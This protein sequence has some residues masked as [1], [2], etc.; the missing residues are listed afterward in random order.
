[1]KMKMLVLTIAM[2]FALVMGISAVAMAGDAEKGKSV[3]NGAG[4]CK[5]CHKTDDKKL[6]GPGLAGVSKLYDDAWLKG[7]IL[8]P[9]GVWAA[10]DPKVEDM[11]KRLNK[12]GKPKTAMAPGKISPEDA[13][14]IVAYLKTL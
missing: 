6:V 14:D 9:Q 12:T 10:G 7:W 11:K 5:A 2:A 1:M 8:D 3:F 4:K 13:D